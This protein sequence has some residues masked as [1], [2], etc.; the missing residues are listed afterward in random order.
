MKSRH[1]ACRALAEESRVVE[2]HL[3]SRYARGKATRCAAARSRCVRAG[4]PMPVPVSSALRYA[5]RSR[6]G[7]SAHPRVRS[8]RADRF[9][10]RRS[11]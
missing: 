2:S 9:D 3:M 10:V 1:S 4:E 7:Y 6:L 5:R 11:K 8:R